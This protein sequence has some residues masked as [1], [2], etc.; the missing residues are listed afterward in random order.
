MIAK[1][2]TYPKHLKALEALQARIS[3]DHPVYERV[4]E[5]IAKRA[6][7]YRGEQGIDYYLSFLDENKYTIL[8]DVRLFD[9]TH[10]FQIDTLILSKKFILILEVK[11]I[12]G[13]LTFD[14]TFHQLIRQLDEKVE[15]F[16]DPILQIQRQTLQLRKWL[17]THSAWKHIPI[18]SLV[19]ISTPRTIVKSINSMKEIS[20][21][22]IHTAKLPFRVAELEHSFSKN[23]LSEKQRHQLTTTLLKHHLPKDS[24]I[25]S[26]Y[27]LSQ[28]EI[29][30]GVF[31][32]ACSFIPI[33][34]Y[35]GKWLCPHCDH[36]SKHAHKK[37]LEEY[38]LIFSLVITNSELRNFLLVPS[39]MAANRLFHSLNL[40]FEG[41]NKARK[42]FLE[43]L[44]QN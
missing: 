2:R 29:I 1:P 25:L 3:H 13:T 36:N 43:G 4:K 34:Y 16:A 18:K 32:P 12:A 40:S 11:N 15:G 20:E 21:L 24:D 22:V 19:I 23:I 39:T 17:A 33:Q 28:E 38:S 6:A 7:G 35:R 41:K 44:Y 8:H 26:Q 37:A 5:N 27:G 30:K 10:F 42:Y 9:G 14:Q 31:C